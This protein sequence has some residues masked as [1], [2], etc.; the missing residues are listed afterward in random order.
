MMTQTQTPG[1]LHFMPPEALLKKPRYGKP[2]D[3][4]SLACVILHVMS[5]QWPEPKD[6]VPEGSMMALTE[7]ERREKYLHSCTP[8]SLKELVKLCLHNVPEE[9]PVISA[10]SR[11]VKDLQANNDQ[12]NP[13][14]AYSFQSLSDKIEF[15]Q[16]IND[17]HQDQ[18]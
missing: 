11:G 4:F 8:L 14:T 10:V 9:R 16:K 12:Q 15:F 2:V 7:V 13:V 17:K 1:T 3:V 5:H 18:T 6:R